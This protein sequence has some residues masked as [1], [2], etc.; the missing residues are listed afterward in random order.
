[1]DP[2]AA[3]GF[4]LLLVA[5]PG[6]STIVEAAGSFCAAGAAGFAVVAWALAEAFLLEAAAAFVADARGGSDAAELDVSARPDWRFM[7]A[8]CL[9][10]MGMLL[11]GPSVPTTGHRQ[12][13]EPAMPRN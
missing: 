2:A 11:P 4:A 8:A 9:M 7:E 13:S 12:R 5:L 10:M 1:M 3:V 6:W